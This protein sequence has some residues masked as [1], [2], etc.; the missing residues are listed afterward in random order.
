MLHPETE[1]YWTESHRDREAPFAS[2]RMEK[3]GKEHR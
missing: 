2:L 1:I 3:E